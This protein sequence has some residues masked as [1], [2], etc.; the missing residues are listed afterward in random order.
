[1]ATK[2]AASAKKSTTKPKQSTTK[3]TTVK[4]VA[5]DKKSRK[6]T[7]RFGK[8]RSPLLGACIAEFIGTFI[9]ASVAVLTK[10]EPLYVGFAL[11]AV[12]LLVGTLSG[13]HVNPLVTVGAWAT[14]KINS[15]RALG[16]LI[17][18]FLGAA[19]ALVV[20]T[21]FIGAAPQPDNS[22][23]SMFAQQTVDLFKVQPVD[24]AKVWYV[25]FS[26]MLAATIFGFAFSSAMREKRDRAAR[27]FT[28]GFGYL[29]ALIVAS[30]L[31]SYAATSGVVNPATAI[32][33]SAVD[34]TN[35]KL[36]SVLIYIVSPII[37]GVVGFFLFDVLRDENDG[38]D[39]HLL[40]DEYRA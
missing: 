9:L 5:A 38:G 24:D 34:W 17:A 12:V 21:A 1:M 35:V 8:G 23:A 18:Q 27:A 11:I 29:V 13:S 32:T 2:K 10:G 28:V 22:Q 3:V 7:S 16:Y 30:V 39:D 36:W 20:M 33:V 19:L 6:V 25:F 4:A 15:P 26:E 31:A 40:K 14:R 37:G